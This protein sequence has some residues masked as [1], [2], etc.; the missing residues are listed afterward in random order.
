MTTIICIVYAVM[1]AINLAMVFPSRDR[2]NPLAFGFYVILG[3]VTQ[4]IILL[5]VIP[6]A[7]IEML[8]RVRIWAMNKPLNKTP[9]GPPADSKGLY[10]VH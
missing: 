4:L 5:M 9:T 7:Y 1:S 8:Q 2:I 10:V 6:Y 3:P